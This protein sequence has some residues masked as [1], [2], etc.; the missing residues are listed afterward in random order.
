MSVK[1][2]NFH[3]TVVKNQNLQLTYDSE[4]N[5]ISIEFEHKLNNGAH[6]NTDRMSIDKSYIRPFIDLLLELEKSETE[7]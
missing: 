7:V 3:R 5:T 1:I 2:T 4:T 6:L